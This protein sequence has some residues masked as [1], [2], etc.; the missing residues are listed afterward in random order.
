MGGYG[1][2]KLA[3][4]FPHLFC[5]ATSHSGPLMTPLYKPETRPKDYQPMLTEF[6]SI[7]GPDWQGGPNDPVALAQ[8][9]PLHLRP[10]LRLDC[11]VGDFL[12]EQNRDFHT[13]LQSLP[14][15]H[16]YEE[17][18]GEHNWAYWDTHIQDAIR[19]HSKVLKIPLPT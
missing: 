12:L 16:E 7:F 18:P 17:F 9:C 3:L 1:A 10:A 5:A 6:E 2:V 13:H 4:K 8:K 14:Y 11:G 15:P 19:F